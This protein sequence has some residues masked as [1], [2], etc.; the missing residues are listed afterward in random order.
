[1]MVEEVLIIGNNDANGF[2]GV[3]PAGLQPS[4]GVSANRKPGEQDVFHFSNKF[5]VFCFLLTFSHRLD[6]G[7]KAD[8]ILWGRTSPAATLPQGKLTSAFQFHVKPNIFAEPWLR[9]I[10]WDL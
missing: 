8:K 7:Q 5:P 2:S 4:T 3:P 6:E 9:E 10:R 1:M